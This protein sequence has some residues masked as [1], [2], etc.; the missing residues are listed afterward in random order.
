[1][2]EEETEVRT[3]FILFLRC[4]SWPFLG[5]WRDCDDVD[6]LVRIVLFEIVVVGAL[7][8]LSSGLYEIWTTPVCPC[9][10]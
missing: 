2:G 3:G 9:M 6:A 5:H 1:M 10:R 4:L 8:V 7:Y